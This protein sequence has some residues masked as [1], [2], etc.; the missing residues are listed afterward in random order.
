MKPTK[1][2]YGIG[3]IIGDCILLADTIIDICKGELTWVTLLTTLLW[4]T[5]LAIPIFVL[6]KRYVR[7]ERGRD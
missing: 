7:K 3:M 5:V 2:K 6:M 1:I 4:S